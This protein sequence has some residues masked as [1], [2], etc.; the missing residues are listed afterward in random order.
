LSKGS[1]DESVCGLRVDRKGTIHHHIDTNIGQGGATLFQS[2][3]D[4]GVS[5]H[6]MHPI[7][8]VLPGEK[9]RCVTAFGTLMK[10]RISGVDLN[11]RAPKHKA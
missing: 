10:A 2:V 1:L 5:I 4:G 6:P 9:Y 11:L 8:A 3:N 7:C